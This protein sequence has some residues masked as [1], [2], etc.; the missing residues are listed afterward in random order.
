MLEYQNSVYTSLERQTPLIRK[1]FPSAQFYCRVWLIVCRASR[2]AKKGEYPG[3]AWAQSSYEVLQEIERIGVRIKI[4]G[5]ENIVE[6]N[7]PA[8]FVGNHMSMMETLLLP[9]IIQPLIDVTFVV[10]ESL[11]D[12]PVFK[13]VMRSRNP[14]SVSRT[15]PRQDFKTVMT[16]GSERLNRGTSVIVFP[17]TTRAQVFNPKQMGSIGVK[18]ARKAGVS[19]IPLAL[20]T[21]GWQNGSIA[22]D[23]GRINTSKTAY[24]AFGEPMEI[25]GRGTEEQQAIND[26][27][28]E[29]LKNWQD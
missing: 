13:Y 3:A 29:K 27:I 15:N 19:V 28:V 8:V 14:V 5:I 6:H 2:M 4:T 7:R 26:F 16:M 9:V 18:L 25:K 10:K 1:I 21:D 17:Q 23:F 24:F 20:K 22:K 11:L 12:Y